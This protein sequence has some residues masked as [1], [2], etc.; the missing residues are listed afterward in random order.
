MGKGFRCAAYILIMAWLWQSCSP[1]RDIMR[2]GQSPERVQ[3]DMQRRQVQP[4][5][6]GAANTTAYLP[7]IQDKKVGVLTNATGRVGD[8]HLIDFLLAHGVQVVSIFAPEHG[9]RGTADAGEHI[10]D[11]KDA[12]TGLPV[13]SLYGNNKK[14]KPEQLA[15]LDVLLFDIQDV[16]ARFYTYIS[17]LH[18]VME[19]CTENKLPLLVLDRPNPVGGVIDGP[20][21]DLKY[22]S[23]VGMHPIP[24]LH[25]LTIGEYAL[26]INGEKWLSEGK[27]CELQV[28]PCLGYTKAM[29]YHVPVKPSPNLPNDQAI[30][31]YASLCFFEGTPISVGRGTPFPFQVYGA[32]F[33]METGFSFTPQPNEGAKDPMYKGQQCNGV[34]LRQTMPFRG[35]QLKY[36]LD[37]YHQA[38][39]ASKFFNAF[40]TKLA[41]GQGLQHDIEACLDEAAI[42]AHWAEG[43]QQFEQM[44]KP[45]LRYALE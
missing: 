7:F 22:N 24:V 38:P 43:L 1:S 20:V 13:I 29:P 4:F 45:Y 9:F 8:Q 26:M 36:L 2:S 33:L 25:G 18:Y 19:A 10:E 39:D 44:R 15:G 34:D 5:C 30:R 32:P 6:V 3:H 12:Q 31:L 21:L 42:R 27:Q 14:P 37:A 16:G 11:G 17:T 35:L 28:I 40:F 23:F 41:G